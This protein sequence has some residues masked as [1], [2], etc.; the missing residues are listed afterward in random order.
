VILSA[1]E[2]LVKAAMVCL[3]EVWPRCL[4]FE[5]LRRLA[6]TRL[7]CTGD[8]TPEAVAH[9]VEVLGQSLLQFYTS[10][11]MSLVELHVHPPRLPERIGQRPAASPLAR[12]QATA[13]NRVTNLRHES[14]G[15]GEF[16][17]QLLRHLDGTRDRAA[18]L[19]V[20]T[21]LAMAGELEVEENGVPVKD[22][23]R[24]GDLIR[25]AVDRQLSLLQHN[26]LLIG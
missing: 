17:R 24:L 25:R 10:A 12:L 9:D 14:V 2:P 5:Q 15:L 13:G 23:P 4:P 19:E 18:L 22:S 26:A 6:Q 21:D 8:Q 16:E 3:A 11:A 20:L 1:G 7:G